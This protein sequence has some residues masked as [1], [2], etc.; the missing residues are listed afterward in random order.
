MANNKGL[1]PNSPFSDALKEKIKALMSRYETVRSSI[2]PILHAIQDEKDWI[3]ETDVETLERDFGLSAVDVREVL[4]FYTMYRKE[5]PAPWRLEVCNS[6]SCWLM[7]SAQTL[8]AAE[9][10]IEDAKAQ[11]KPVPFSCREVEC[12]GYC[13]RAPVAFVNKDRHYS[14]TPEKAIE[15][16]KNYSS[17]E[18]PAAAKRCAQIIAEEGSKEG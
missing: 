5:P 10:Y 3:S 11:G 8:K 12:L 13:G 14:V 9:A 6:I 15:L 18:I 1:A 17:K 2:L 7:G 4:T 16:I